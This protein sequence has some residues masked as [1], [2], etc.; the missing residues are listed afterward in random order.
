MEGFHASLSHLFNNFGY[1]ERRQRSRHGTSGHSTRDLANGT[2]IDLH[3]T[4]KTR[5][6]SLFPWTKCWRRQPTEETTP[7]NALQPTKLRRQ[8][9]EQ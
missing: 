9:H 2:A 3:E 8:T 4:S 7:T 1:S 6:I 5:Q